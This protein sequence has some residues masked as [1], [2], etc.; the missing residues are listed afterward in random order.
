MKVFKFSPSNKSLVSSTREDVKNFL[1]KLTRFLKEIN[2]EDEEI[3]NLVSLI[4]PIVEACQKMSKFSNCTEI[5]G[6][7]AIMAS[8]SGKAMMVFLGML[9]EVMTEGDLAVQ[10]KELIKKVM[11]INNVKFCVAR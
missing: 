11:K 8:V 2:I 1:V 3:S 7:L 9:N 10:N 5:K 6:K 4:E